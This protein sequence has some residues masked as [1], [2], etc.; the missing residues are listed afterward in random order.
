MGRKVG[1]AIAGLVFVAAALFLFRGELGWE[2][3]EVAPPPV[4]EPRPEPRMP[5]PRPP[6]APDDDAMPAPPRPPAERPRVELPPLARSDA[7]IRE[8]LEAFGLPAE[9]VGQDDLVRRLAVVTDAVTRGEWP[10]RPLRF[11]QA[12]GPFRVIERDGKLYPDP[13]NATR[14]EPDLELLESIEPAATARFLELIEPLLGEALAELGL[15]TSGDLALREAIDAVLE[16]PVEP[17]PYAL[18]QPKVFYEYADPAVEAR[19]PF[20]KQLLRLG[21][22]NAARLKTYLR[23]VKESLE[24]RER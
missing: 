23:R 3:R 7:F 9:W 17:G 1:F 15:T 6:T 18:V 10:R 24:D 21:P 19:A 20:E 11:L 16:T 13:R 22:E 4:V 14:Y 5:V 12:P 2:A 8:R